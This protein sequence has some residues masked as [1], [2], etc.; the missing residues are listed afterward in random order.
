MSQ[1]SA[2]VAKLVTLERSFMAHFWDTILEMF[3]ANC[4]LLQKSDVNIF[5]GMS[6]SE[7]LH[8]FVESLKDESKCIERV[9]SYVSCVPQSYKHDLQRSRKRKNFS[10][11]I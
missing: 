2:L 1:A 6:L 8:E 4:L 11:D 9:A 7:S 3:Q 10:D 5:T